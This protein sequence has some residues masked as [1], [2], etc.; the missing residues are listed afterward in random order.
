MM[1]MPAEWSPHER[2]LIGWPCRESSWR[3]TLDDGRREFAEVANQLVQFE[4][5]TMVCASEA[6]QENARSLLSSAVETVVI[7][8]DGSWLR[9]NG[10]IFVTDEN[11]RE[12]L[13]FRFNAWGE[14]HA[15]RDR[16][17]ALGA[18]LAEKVGDEVRKVDVVFEGGAIAVDGSGV[19]AV[20]EGCL[21]HPSRNWQHTKEHVEQTLKESLGIEKLIWLPEGLAEDLERD[22]ENLY[23]G[24]DGHVDLFMDFIAPNTCLLLSVPDDNPNAENLASCKNILQAADVTVIDFPYL[25]SF[26][27]KGKEFIA[28]YLNFY[29]CNGAVLVPV[30]GSEP[31]KD[32]EVLGVIA[33]HWPDR[34]VVPVRMRAGP[35]QGGAVHCMTQQ[36]PV[37]PS[38]MA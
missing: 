8:M 1:R 11:S 5:V 2:T 12:A 16:D 4:P 22:P 19:L 20:A 32:E 29:V 18:T 10:P 25:S 14:R 26:E 9:D 30:A 33:G 23:Y 27:Y 21:M 13:H 31:D 36:V 7:P 6:D 24:T 37:K 3:E 34:E 17:A 15:E 38:G 28:S 35:M